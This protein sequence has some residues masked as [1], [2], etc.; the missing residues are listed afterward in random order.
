MKTLTAICLS[1]A[2]F[3]I[4]SCKTIFGPPKTQVEFRY[5]YELLEMVADRTE[6]WD[7]STSPIVDAAI[8]GITPTGSMGREEFRIQTAPLFEAHDALAP[9]HAEPDRLKMYLSETK[10]LRLVAGQE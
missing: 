2:A 3:S 10:V 7:P 5:V 4:G 9:L 1:L 6:T 8:E